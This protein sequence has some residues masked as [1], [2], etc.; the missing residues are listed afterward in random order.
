MNNTKQKQVMLSINVFVLVFLMTFI[1]RVVKAYIGIAYPDQS[2]ISVQN[3]ITLPSIYGM[4]AALLIGP[5]AL[6]V[7]KSTL[8]SL[9]MVF[10][11][12]HCVVFYLTGLLKLPF[13]L[14][15]VASFLGGVAIG[16]YI[17]LLNSIIS[18]HFPAEKR[19]DCIAQYN[20]WINIGGVVITYAAGWLAAGNNGANWYNA[21][22]L[23]I[24]SIVGLIVFNILAKKND[25]DTP[26]ITAEAP[27]SADKAKK[28]GIRDIPGK[29]FGWI[30]LM[31][32][33]HGLF[34]VTQNAFNA[35]VSSYIITEYNLGTS[36][37]A[38]TATSL[39]RFALIPFTAL[40]PV[41]RKYLK[42]WMIPI[43]Y[44]VMGIGLL[45]M[46]VT[47][48]LAGAYICAILCGL[49][50]ALVHSA[51]YAKAS[52]YVPIAL[53]PISMSLV[54]CLVNTGTGF[55]SYILEFFANMLGGGMNNRFLAG[56]IISVVIAVAAVFM[57]IVKK[58]TYS[59][60]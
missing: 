46:M 24:A 10:M 28:P 27:Q 40:Y 39:V 5:I 55:S 33:V 19:G 26:S 21:Y 45:V 59:E 35:N 43:G 52:R 2:D 32:L 31:G 9:T 7:R 37:Q 53:V 14:L 1:T 56:M 51:F 42:D 17:P 38:G 11:I 44:L 22:L 41:F 57:Y 4:V 58:P 8:T 34:Y 54:S 15:Q 47:K 6:K 48:S 30:I 20:V 50:T 13:W 12:L 23:G 29:V 3:L 36:V 25:I 49:S 18:D 60:E 16:V